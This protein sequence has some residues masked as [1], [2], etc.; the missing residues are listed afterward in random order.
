MAQGCHEFLSL[1]TDEQHTAAPAPVTVEPSAETRVCAEVPSIMDAAGFAQIVP[2]GT[3]FL[4][5][6]GLCPKSR[7]GERGRRLGIEEGH[8][9]S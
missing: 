5:K 8:H 9:G 2:V 6:W 1:A 7:E 3:G 4:G